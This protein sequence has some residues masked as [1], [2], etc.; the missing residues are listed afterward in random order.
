MPTSLPESLSPDSIDTLTELSAILARL[1]P[2]HLTGGG[3]VNGSNGG[4]FSTP[5][6]LPDSVTGTTPRP[7]TST[8]ANL[9]QPAPPLLASSSAAAASGEVLDG[10]QSGTGGTIFAL[11]D[12]PTAT[13]G[14]KHKLQRARVQ[15]R[16]LPDMGRTVSQQ[17]EEI[18]ELEGRIARQR[19]VLRSLREVGLRFAMGEE[20][21]PSRDAPDVV[22]QG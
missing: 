1:R 18:A 22:M 15:I 13:D 20:R 11:K 14:L 5:A 21:P 2:A 6:P 9:A 4:T 17:Q 8:P 3:I 19:E 16:E 12:I 10:G 7:S